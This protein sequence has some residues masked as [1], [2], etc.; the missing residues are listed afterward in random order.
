M[1]P[2]HSRVE[3]AGPPLV[4]VHGVG[5]DHTMWDPVVEVLAQQYR[6]L[7]Y[8]LLGHGRSDDPPGTRQLEDFVAQLLEVLDIHQIENCDLV[9]LS[10]GGLVALTAAA[11]HP[12]RVRRVVLVSTVFGRSESQRAGV[13]QRLELAEDEG[14]KPVA[15]LAIER[16]FTPQWRASH[17]AETDSVRQRILTTDQGGYLKAYRLFVES[18]ALAAAL[19]PAVEAPALALA[20]ERDTGSTPEMAVALA[21]AIP[22]GEARILPGVHHL[23]PIE[24]PNL[25]S[26]ALLEFL[27]RENPSRHIVS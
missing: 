19:A 25:F 10:L 22:Y 12:D 6:V 3:G 2:T 5:L 7:R 26:S 9:G 16:W 18:D 23:A 13:Q 27:N 21:D 24:E 20:G 14:L 17:P 4:L 11:R 15:D 8:D 1:N